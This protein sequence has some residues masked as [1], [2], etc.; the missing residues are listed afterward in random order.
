LKA[1]NKSHSQKDKEF[2]LASTSNTCKK[3]SP[4]VCESYDNRL[5]CFPVFT[6]NNGAFSVA[7]KVSKTSTSLR[8][9][10]RDDGILIKL[11]CFWRLST[12]MVFI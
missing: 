10:V 7:V 5:L 2:P 11:L 12:V 4:S 3:K 8:S 1:K 6:R 9:K